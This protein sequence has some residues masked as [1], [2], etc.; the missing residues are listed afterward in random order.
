MGIGPSRESLPCEPGG[1]HWHIPEEVAVVASAVAAKNGSRW[2]AGPGLALAAADANRGRAP[3]CRPRGRRSSAQFLSW[4]SKSRSCWTPSGGSGTSSWRCG[5]PQVGRHHRGGRA[6]KSL[7]LAQPEGR[8]KPEGLLQ[9]EER[10]DLKETGSNA[11][12]S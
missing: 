7:C 9:L 10:K 12:N 3:T 11:I 6:R 1:H 8:R 2:I 5:L 4:S